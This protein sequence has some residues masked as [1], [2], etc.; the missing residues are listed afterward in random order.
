MGKEYKSMADFIELKHPIKINGKDVK[1]LSYDS[2]SIT[3]EQFMEVSAR[4][5][6]ELASKNI[7]PASQ[8]E[9]NVALHMQLGYQAI[10]NCNS[11]IDVEDLKRI[12]GAADILKVRKIGYHFLLGIAQD[13]QEEEN[14]ST[15]KPSEDSS[16][17]TV[18]STTKGQKASKS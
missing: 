2:D 8:P 18:E 13:D 16:E 17:T 12:N 5:D 9:Y 11:D 10:I 6:F 4:S 1:K 3:A 7:M 15:Q 14:P